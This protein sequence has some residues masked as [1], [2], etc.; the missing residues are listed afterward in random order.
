MQPN[1]AVTHDMIY[2]A[3][4]G[5]VFMSGIQALVRLPLM[6][7]R[8]D[9]YNGLNTAG[10]VSGYRGSPLGGYDL[11]LWK[12]AQYLDRHRSEER[13]VGKEC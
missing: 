11:N 8:L 10:L 7:R 13:R 3:D 4:E 9:R 6:Q 12:A 2:E 1:R 5:P